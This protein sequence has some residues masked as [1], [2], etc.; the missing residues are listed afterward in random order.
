MPL[1]QVVEKDSFGTD[2][3]PVRYYDKALT[4]FDDEQ[5]ANQA[6]IDYVTDRNCNNA[7]TKEEKLQAA[8]V[9]MVMDDGMFLGVLDKQPWYLTYPRDT[10]SSTGEACT[11]G[12]VVKDRKFFGLEGK[13]EVSV[14]PIPGS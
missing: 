3:Q 5:E 9:F 4:R 11:K 12:D 6:A 8:E 14:R 13:A 1:Y 2:W 10:K 7:L